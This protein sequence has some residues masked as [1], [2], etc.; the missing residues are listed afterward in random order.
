MQKLIRIYCSGSLWDLFYNQN[1]NKNALWIWSQIVEA[2]KRVF[3]V[4]RFGSFIIIL[5]QK[6]IG[7]QNDN[8]NKE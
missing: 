3:S 5:K 8:H 7:N 2:Y 4:D 1:K 6:K